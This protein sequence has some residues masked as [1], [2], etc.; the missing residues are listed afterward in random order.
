MT[1]RNGKRRIAII[2]MGPR[3]LGALEALAARVAPGSVSVEIFDPV[4]PYGA[5]PN[6][7]P[8]E[9]ELCLL[10]LPVRAVQIDPGRVGRFAD[11]LGVEDPE[12]YP[13]R[14]DL[15]RY[16]AARFEAVAESLAPLMHAARVENVSREADGWYLEAD[17]RHGPFDEVLTTQGQPRCEPD[18][19]LAE[20]QNHAK[21]Q[22]L[23][24]FAAY[25]GQALRAAAQGWQGKV[26]GVRGLGLST[27]DVMRLLT[28]GLGG[29]F[30]DG[31]YVPSGREP[32]RILP[33][34][35]DG[36][37]PAPKP[38]T[39]EVDAGFDPEEGETRAFI[40]AL[41]E[42]VGMAAN[43]A[44]ERICAALVAPGM[45][46]AQAPRREVERWL[47][48]EREAPGSQETRGPIE[49]L[50]AHMDMAR[51]AV[52][53]VGYAL[54]QVWRKWQNELRQG[55]NPARMA[56][57]TAAALVKF[58]DALKRFSYGPPLRS[59]EELLALIR[60]DVVDLRAVDDPDIRLVDDGWVLDGDAATL[61]AEV[62]VDAVL[63]S[64]ALAPV[65]DRA[66]AGLREDGWL[67]EVAEGLG[68]ETAADGL[69]LT[70]DGRPAPGLA[71]LGRMAA[72]SVIAV[73]SIHDCFG[74][75]ADR[76]ANGVA[77]RS[78]RRTD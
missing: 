11:W 3:G 37:A 36:H 39:S 78:G 58:D 56:P 48:A 64:P 12:S 21:T 60:A 1:G 25:P 73:D 30:E 5:G 44:L 43:A 34:S 15:G 57:E 76:W 53:E 49:A 22:G 4:R 6:F 42:A 47:A 67:H 8:D 7:S 40:G 52:P 18:A 41:A 72:G 2:G 63:P 77:D 70:R 20:W 69:A 51:G 32:A 71:V 9:S 74:A 50:A 23:P 14:A 35:L 13:P 33:F 61:R 59:A 17:G 62:M 31:A 45:R 65:T 24:L 10:N 66:L 28:L 16:F 38:A 55:F 68:G 19:Q 29:R 75:A 54:G 27:L 26:V 46:L